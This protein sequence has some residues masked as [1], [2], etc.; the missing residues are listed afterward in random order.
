M[1]G[2][3]SIGHRRGQSSSL[4]FE[5]PQPLGFLHQQCLELQVGAKEPQV[6][7]LEKVGRIGKYD[8]A[9]AALICA[10]LHPL[11]ASLAICTQY[12]RRIPRTHLACE[13]FTGYAPAG[14]SYHAGALDGYRLQL[15]QSGATG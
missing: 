8:H 14:F 11:V 2:Y 1:A 12:K 7:P 15:C 3:Y 4:V 6:V 10:S 5:R 13:G 9:K